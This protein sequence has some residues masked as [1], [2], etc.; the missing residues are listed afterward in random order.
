V[1]KT[2]F[3]GA[4]KRPCYKSCCTDTATYST[5][6]TTL[7]EI[8]KSMPAGAYIYIYIYIFDKQGDP[9]GA[10]VRV[11]DKVVQPTRGGLADRVDEHN[12]S[13]RQIISD[14]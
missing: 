2:P 12:S 14:N 9:I 10:G 13:S 7:T 5:P 1:V 6:K 8:L 4:E 11:G 3:R